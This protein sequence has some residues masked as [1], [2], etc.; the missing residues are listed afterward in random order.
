[1]NEESLDLIEKNADIL[2]Q[3]IG[4]DF[5]DDQ[6]ALDMWKDAGADI[7]GTRV[8]FPLG[9][10]RSIIQKSAPSQYI[11]HARNKNRNV[12]IGGDNTVLVPAYGSPF[13]YDIHGGRRYA[14][15]D[16]FRNFVN[17][18]VCFNPHNM[19]ICKSK[20]LLSSYYN[21]VFPWLEKCYKFGLDKNLY[22][23]YNKRLIAFL[24]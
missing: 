6:E 17:K 20:K 24:M 1:M 7:D 3:E 16:D 13:V 14:T 8:R 18:E 19:F 15:I 2:L 11:Q 22:N 4:I 10:C 12:V 9:L 21:E 23:G 5:L